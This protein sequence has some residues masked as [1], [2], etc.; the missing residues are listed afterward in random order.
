MERNGN[1]AAG[2][3]EH[4]GAARLHQRGERPRERSSAFVFEGVNHGAQR[5]VVRA[6]RAGT[7][8]GAIRAPAART[9]RQ[10]Q[11]DLAPR[12]QRIAAAI[13]ERRRERE[14]RLPAENADRSVRGVIERFVARRAGGREH[15]AEDCVG[16]G[17]KTCD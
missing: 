16:G 14:D 7:I 17:L 11:A 6:N 3:V 15:D 2:A 12:R 4:V 8:D 13:A 9:P 10:R 5:A 1:R